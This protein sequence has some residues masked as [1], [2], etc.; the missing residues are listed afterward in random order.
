M[1]PSTPRWSGPSGGAA[2]C[3]APQVPADLEPLELDGLQDD[4]GWSEREIRGTAIGADAERVGLTRCTVAGVRFSAARLHRWELTDV[5]LTDC[6]L[7]N[8]VLE[9]ATM[10][11]VAFERCRLTGA[12]LG[13]ALLTD[14]RF[15]DCQLDDLGLRMVKAERLLVE[16]GSAQRVDLYRARLAGSTWHGV[17]LTGADLSGADLARARLH[18]STLVDLT[19]ASALKGTV[20]DASQTVAVG[21]A[22][23]TDATI[24]IDDD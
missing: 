1:A 3:R 20:I 14:V 18:G 19:G 11:R 16:G 17:D 6:D 5:T 13:G 22:L 2:A 8:V 7:A 4:D 10:V 24:T 21:L 15:V 23:I 9:E 12:D